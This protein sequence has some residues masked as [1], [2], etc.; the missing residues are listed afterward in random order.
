MVNLLFSGSNCKMEISF[1]FQ[2]VDFAWREEEDIR[3]WIIDTLHKESV[4]TDTGEI[5]IIFC[6]DEYLLD[7]NIQYLDHDYY[8]DI[9]TFAYSHSPF[10]ADLYISTDRVKENANDMKH[11]FYEELYRVIIHGIL[12]SCGYD[13]KTIEEQKRIRA[14]EDE[15]LK[16]ILPIVQGKYK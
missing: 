15:Y 9:I 1:F 12:H 11:G 13:D 16:T 4:Q 10:T 14:K 8:T 7:I 2:D 6:S 5:S 3:Q